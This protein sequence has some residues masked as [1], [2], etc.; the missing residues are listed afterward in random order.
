MYHTL[1]NSHL[2]YGILS[3]GSTSSTNLHR[4]QVLQN[5]A[6][7]NM[8]KAPRFFRLDNFFLNLRILKV[9]HLYD[10]EIAKFMHGHFNGELPEC[11]LNYFQRTGTRHNYYTRATE[12]LLYDPIPCRTSRGQRSIQFYWPK[13]W[14]DIP[15]SIKNI[16]KINFKREFKSLI[17]SLY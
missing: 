5:R 17:F 9:E 15:L 2:Q 1:F 7:R 14:N 3:W 16:S 6:I 12:N 13:V 11:F 4:L 10:L 8:M